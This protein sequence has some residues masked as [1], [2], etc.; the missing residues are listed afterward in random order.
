MALES[1]YFNE[2]KLSSVRSRMLSFQAYYLI[3][4]LTFK[5]LLS[6]YSSY[7]H[8]NCISSVHA[9]NDEHI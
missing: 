3:I 9:L 1:Q 6:F 2:R 5:R 7:G 8:G 4:N